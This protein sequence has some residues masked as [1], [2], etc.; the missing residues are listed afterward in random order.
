VTPEERNIEVEHRVWV[1]MFGEEEADR[2]RMNAEAHD[3]L[4]Q[5]DDSTDDQA[6]SG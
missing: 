1:R 5:L 2:L 4:R 6:G 3:L